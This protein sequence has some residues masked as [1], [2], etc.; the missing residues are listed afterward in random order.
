MFYGRENELKKLQ[1]AFKSKRQETLLIYGRRRIG[2][3]E[4]IRYS[5]EKSE[6]PMIYYE[7]LEATEK[8]NLEGLSEVIS[9]TF[10][11]EGISFNG[12]GK[13][14]QF[15]FEQAKEN[16][17]ILVLDEY[18]YLRKKA[19]GMDSILQ[20]LIDQ[21]RTSSQLK[22]ILCGSY[23]DVM[24]SLL[25]EE[26]PL[27]GRISLSIQL[28]QM[29]YLDASKFYPGFSE[30]EKVQ[31]YS[32]FGGVPYYCELIDP[33]LSVKENI[34]SLISGQDARLQNEVQ[35]YLKNEL[36]KME[37]ANS[38]F[39][40]LAS[41]FSQFNEILQS[42]GIS[43][44]PTLADVMNRLVEMEIVEKRFPINK[45]DNKKYTKYYI[46]DNLSLFYFRYI[47]RYSSQRRVMNPEVFYERYIEEDFHEHF[48]PDAFEKIS[49]QFLIRRNINGKIEP[50]FDLI[51]SY[52]YDDPIKKR[53]VSS[54]L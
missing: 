32:V 30:E 44:S 8:K 3:S 15:V 53:T 23:V 27:Y 5:C 28:R 14:L 29:D 40:S 6:I 16:P 48:V 31:L 1:K 43:S 7:C 33:E 39:D 10:N 20:S 4:L 47:F 50:P 36:S 38:V 25:Q 17:M 26:N 22:L 21:Y 2:K 18:P 54:T 13:A 9:Q 11:L 35:M 42:S 46:T 12:V 45:P 51:G 37:N 49:R 34:I 41:G 24:K 19:E 52:A